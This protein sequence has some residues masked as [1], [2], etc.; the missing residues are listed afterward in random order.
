MMGHRPVLVLSEF[1]G[2]QEMD[3][4]FALLCPYFSVL[5][6][7]RPPLTGPLSLPIIVFIL[8]AQCP[9][10]LSSLNLFASLH[11]LKLTLF[12]PSVFP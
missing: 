6:Q 7:L 2:C 10:F 12:S 5:P 1:W 9:A 4:L 11:K 3:P 8:E